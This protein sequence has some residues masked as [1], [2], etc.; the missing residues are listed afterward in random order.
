L[1]GFLDICQAYLHLQLGVDAV[2]DAHHG[3]AADHFTAA[4]IT[5][6]VWSKWAMKYNFEVFLEVRTSMSKLTKDV[7]YT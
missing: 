3:E 1:S 4:I 5:G 6:A 2:D 7:K